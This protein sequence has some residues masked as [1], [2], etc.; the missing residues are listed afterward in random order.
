MGVME[1]T[2]ARILK[3]APHFLRQLRRKSNKLEA[4]AHHG[5]T[6]MDRLKSE[7]C[8]AMVN[9]LQ[10][11]CPLV[12]YCGFLVRQCNWS[13]QRPGYAIDAHHDLLLVFILLT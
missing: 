3:C 5:G 6:A 11:W 9:L 8:K 10:N 13:G 2:I 4:A 7:V 12:L 1:T